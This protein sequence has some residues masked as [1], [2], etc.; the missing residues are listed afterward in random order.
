[1]DHYS[2]LKWTAN[3]WMDVIWAEK[4]LVA[5]ELLHAKNFIDRS[6]SGRE[7]D[8]QSY[9]Q[10]INDFFQS[11]PDFFARVKDLVV[12]EQEDKVAI[13]WEAEGTFQGEFMGYKPHG[14]RIAFRGIE[15][16]KINDNLVTERWGEWDGLYLLSQLKSPI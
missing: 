2:E 9:K 8:A 15:V 1:M 11:F 16:I 6:P 3:R 5:F 4:N 14:R 12:D 7:P 10:S 13:R